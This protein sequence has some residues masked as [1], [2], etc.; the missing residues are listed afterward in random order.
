M[1]RVLVVAAAAAAAESNRTINRLYGGVDP[2]VDH[3]CQAKKLPDKYLVLLSAWEQMNKNIAVVAE[4]AALAHKLGRTFVEPL[5]CRSR[6]V[7]PFDHPRDAGAVLCGG[8]AATP[9]GGVAGWPLPRRRRKNTQV[10]PS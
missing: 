8:L 9:R 10:R 3:K 1:H 2:H 4:A 5:Y 7:P 6:V